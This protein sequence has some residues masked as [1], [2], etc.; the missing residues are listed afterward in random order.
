MPS[1]RSAPC[2]R[3]RKEGDL[4][5]SG[6][7]V[8][9]SLAGS[10]LPEIGESGLN[11]HVSNDELEFLSLFN[12]RKYIQFF[13][14]QPWLICDCSNGTNFKKWNGNLLHAN[15]EPPFHPFRIE[16]G[17]PKLGNPF[18]VLFL[19]VHDQRRM[20]NF[21]IKFCHKPKSKYFFF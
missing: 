11:I 3:R 18:L 13:P 12:S 8:Q 7:C 20:T 19:L 1:F 9:I 21:G 14:S 6:F 16:I 10:P 5:A 2:E 17:G 4:K 15:F